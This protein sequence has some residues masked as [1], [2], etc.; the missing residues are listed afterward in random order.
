MIETIIAIISIAV[1]GVLGMAIMRDIKA[2]MTVS[3]SLAPAARTTTVNGTSLDLQNYIGDIM[4]VLN[5]AAGT[6]TSPTLDVKLQDSADDSAF[7][8]VA[9]KTF[10]QI[11]GT[12]SLQ[13]MNIDVR[14]VRRYI[15][16]VA[17]IGGTSPSFTCVGTFQGMKQT[18]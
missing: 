12:A 10:T 16:L 15:R 14:A 11:T 13:T 5:S 17:T 8:D 6:G 7:A 2:H 9:G 4:A 3:N 18:L 1:F